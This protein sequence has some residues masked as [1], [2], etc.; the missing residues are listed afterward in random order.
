MSNTS[1]R[2]ANLFRLFALQQTVRAV[3]QPRKP[4]HRALRMGFGL[5]GLSLLVLLVMFGV[6]VGAA[7]LVVGVAWR[8]WKRR[9]QPIAHD[10]RVLDAQ[11]RVVGKAMLN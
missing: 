11:Y 3:L 4:R 1:F 5:V 2:L 10:R 7:M 6:V 9:G 8:L